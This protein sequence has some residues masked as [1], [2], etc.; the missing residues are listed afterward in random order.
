MSAG[1]LRL[2]YKPAKRPTNQRGHTRQENFSCTY[3]AIA[4]QATKMPSTHMTKETQH[5]LAYLAVECAMICSQTHVLTDR[6]C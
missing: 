4:R 5:P 3:A 1:I 6:C 2:G